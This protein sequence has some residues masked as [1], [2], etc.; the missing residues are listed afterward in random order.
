MK[1]KHTILFRVDATNEMGTGHFYRCFALAQKLKDLGYTTLFLTT[2]KNE[3]LL[4]LLSENNIGVH[5]IHYGYPNIKEFKELSSIL[6]NYP[7]PTLI[8]DGYHFDS[9]YHKY[10]RKLKIYFVIIDDQT[11]LS[12]YNSDLIINQNITAFEK[13]YKKDNKTKLLLGCKFVILR[14]EFDSWMGKKRPINRNIKKILITLG[15]SDPFDI[16][17]K[18]MELVSQIITKRIE[19]IVIIGANNNKTINIPQNIENTR[20]KYTIIKNAKNMAKL[21][22]G[23]DIAITAGGTTLW[24]LA[25][26]GV[27]SLVIVVAKNQ[28]NNAK[29]LTKLKAIE[30]LGHNTQLNKKKLASHLINIMNSYTKRKQLSLISQILID[31]RGKERISLILEHPKLKIRRLRNNDRNFLWELANDPIA[32][33]QSYHTK[34]IAWNDHKRWFRNILSNPRNIVYIAILNNKTR[35][36]VIRYERK[37]SSATISINIS[38]THRDHGY[39]KCLL[40][41]TSSQIFHDEKINKILAYIK[42][43]NQASIH[44]FKKAGYEYMD[45]KIIKGNLTRIFCLKKE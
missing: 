37:Y 33:N 7:K 8:L 18:I 35:I 16:T 28:E 11:T 36:G 3:N 4:K 31:G 23:A 20:V 39:G 22:A 43:S 12:R 34:S 9:I 44:M 27:P 15:G 10:I 40:M 2:I 41:L 19:F 26:M 24:E 42:A 38:P 45:S 6:K 25:F 29:R 32:R 14:K 17:S 21:M 1:P 13:K 5:K 30:Y